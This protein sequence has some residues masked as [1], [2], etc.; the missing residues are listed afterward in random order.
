MTPY[1]LIALSTR[2]A[3]LNAA[4]FA[5]FD[6]LFPANRPFITRDGVI[7]VCPRIASHGENFVRVTV[8]TVDGPMVFGAHELTPASWRHVPARLRPLVVRKL[9]GPKG[10]LP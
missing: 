4:F 5:E 7:G 2:A 9:A 6:R 1:D 10:P 8:R 3:Q